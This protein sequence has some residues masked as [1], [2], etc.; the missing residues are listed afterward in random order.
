MREISPRE[1]LTPLR[2]DYMVKHRFFRH[3]IS[4]DDPDAERVYRW[5]I[6]KR[7]NGNEPINSEKN[8]VD[9]YVE[10][11]RYLLHS[12]RTN[13]FLPRFGLSYRP[14]LLLVK[15][16]AHRVAASLALGIDVMA[17]AVSVEG[18]AT[19]DY[20]WFARKGMERSDLDR[21]MDDWRKFESSD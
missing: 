20:G 2:L 9:D 13:G 1:L 7:T 4:G 15:G 12:L 8:T 11:C 16:G 19:W 21:L 10:D 6:Q 14:T 17:E 3:L 5:H 18:G